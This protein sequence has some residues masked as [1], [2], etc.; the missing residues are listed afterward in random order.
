MKNILL[1][2]PIYPS[3][4]LPYDT[5]VVHY[6]T[7]EWVK[8]GYNVCVV[9]YLVN[10]PKIVHWITIPFH[11]YLESKY[12]SVVRHSQASEKEYVY[13]G[14][15][16]K[17]IPLLKYAPH[18][19]Y[20][21]RQIE[22]AYSKTIDYCRQANYIPDVIISH[23]VNPQLEI[24]SMLKDY[25]NVP[26]CFVSH[27]SGTDLKTIYKSEAQNFINKIDVFG[28]RSDYIKKKFET[29]F[30]IKKPSFL[31]YSGIP[32]DMVSFNTYCNRDFSAI[33]KFIFV[34]TLIKR[35]FPTEIIASL[36]TSFKDDF[37]SMTY[38]GDGAERNNILKEISKLSSTQKVVLAGK[39]PRNQVVEKLLDN[40]V[41]I[42]ISR[43][44][45]FGLVYLEAMA[46][47]CITIA[48]YREGFDGIIKH[49]VNGF[50]CEAGDV[51]GLAELI[52]EIRN[53]PIEKINE[54]SRNAIKTASELT[55]YNV[56]KNYIKIIEEYADS[57]DI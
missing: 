16:V 17:R 25:Y 32:Q 1:L 22:Q 9:H 45:T 52:D 48:S 54:I 11:R 56:A 31:C 7:K 35:K 21:K 18:T 13:E 14:V 23:W 51:Q 55:D 24:M 57:K 30:R 41:F 50:L 46:R 40:Q 49:G 34:G 12:A 15:H 28:Y 53:L 6:F 36:K 33:N 4:D 2:T 27:D 42:M 47:G 38:V 20:S 10:F 3:L 19:R 37:F 8:M 26:T 44:E 5:P 39:L 43:N 29:T